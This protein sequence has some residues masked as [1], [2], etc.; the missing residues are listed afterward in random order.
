MIIKLD[1][2]GDGNVETIDTDTASRE[3]LAEALIKTKKTLD[4]FSGVV[5]RRSVAIEE[6]GLD[7]IDGRKKTRISMVDAEKAFAA[8]MRM[9]A[10][11]AVGE[12]RDREAEAEDD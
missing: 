5:D 4:W 3:E 1:D 9:H 10:E 11:F 12:A 8:L 2:D 6:I 7:L